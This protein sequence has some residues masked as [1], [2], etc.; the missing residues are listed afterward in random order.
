MLL[1]AAVGDA[2]GA[3]FECVDKEIVEKHNILKYPA[4]CFKKPDKYIPS[5]PKK[6]TDDT[7]MA[8]ALQ[9]FMIEGQ[10]W[11]PLNLANK[12]VDCFKRDPRKGYAGH[13]YEFLCNIKDGEEF[14][15]KIRPDS[16]RSG[17]AM[18]AMPLGFLSDK[19][20]IKEKCDMQAAL[21]HNT[22]MGKRSAY[23]SAL[24]THMFKWKCAERDEIFTWLSDVTGVDVDPW[25]L[26]E[27]VP[28]NGWAC[29]RAAATS[30]YLYDDMLDI[31]KQCIAFTGDTDTIATIAMYA[32]SFGGAKHFGNHELVKNLENGKYG[33]DYLKKIDYEFWDTF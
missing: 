24:I 20:E 18:R 8:L 1:E 25:D 14:L 10:E 5:P 4:K 23:V 32:V 17:A 21:T 26:E 16:E 7:Q 29:V 3:I 33:R 31:L 27:R 19:M 11:T 6:Y 30:I 2:Y 12:F 28:V 13:F 22:E 9:E 15:E